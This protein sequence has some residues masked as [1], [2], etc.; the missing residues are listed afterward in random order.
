MAWKHSN[1]IL[2][3]CHRL[4]MKMNAVLIK[5]GKVMQVNTSNLAT[6]CLKLNF[7]EMLSDLTTCPFE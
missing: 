7:F 6:T 1:L 2:Q 5:S 3:T 4:S